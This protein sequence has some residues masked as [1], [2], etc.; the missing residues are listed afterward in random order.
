MA[1]EVTRTFDV[2]ERIL[3]ELPR[4]DALGGKNGNDWYVYSTSEYVEK[5]HQLALDRKS[6]V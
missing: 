1:K 2:L 3:T 6:V 4:L 5:S